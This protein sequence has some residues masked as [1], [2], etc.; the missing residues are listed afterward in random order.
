MPVFLIALPIIALS[1]KDKRGLFT[2]AIAFGALALL[3]YFVDTGSLAFLQLSVNGVVFGL[4]FA[5]LLRRKVSAFTLLSVGLIPALMVQLFCEFDPTYGKAYQEMLTKGLSIAEQTFGLSGV[6]DGMSVFHKQ[7]LFPL[8]ELAGQAITLWV[9]SLLFS[10]MAGRT[11]PRLADIDAPHA[12]VLLLI[13]GLGLAFLSGRGGRLGNYLLMVS[14]VLYVINGI[15]VVRLF[16]SRVKGSRF[17][18]GLFY[19]LQMGLFMMPLFLLG[20]LETWL[21]FRKRI[22]KIAMQESSN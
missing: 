8:S 12:F 9:L 18:E 17:L 21:S 3:S 5:F 14:F 10:K 7:Y 13:S 22:F 20:L 1:I 4:L 6:P 19:L 11:R 15:S 16:F 2:V